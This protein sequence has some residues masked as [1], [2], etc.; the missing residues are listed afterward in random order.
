MA[1]EDA[2]KLFVAG[3]PEAMSE[4]GLRELFASSGSNVE[5]LSMPRDRMTGRPRGFAFVR[6]ASSEEADAARATLDGTLVDGRSISV[7][8]FSPEPPSRGERGPGIALRSVTGSSMTREPGGAGGG[9]GGGGGMADRMGP[10]RGPGGGADSGDRTLYVGNLPYD[11]SDNDVK[12]LFEQ[13][14]IPAP[15]RI[16]LPTDPE[17]R[18]RGFGFVTVA[19]AEEA[20][21]SLDKLKDA[22]VRGR[23]LVVNIAHPKGDRPAPRAGGGFGGPP[24]GGFDRGGPGGGGGGGGPAGGGYGGAG[25]PGG[26]GGAPGTPDERRRRTF[27]ADDKPGGASAAFG[28]AGNKKRRPLEPKNVD[29]KRGGGGSGGGWEEDDY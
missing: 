7:R 20:V 22:Q 16:H 25:G 2:C 21:S 18:K 6:L 26:P 14:A 4:E 8:P 24:G 13:L 12:E 19:S 29:K 9:G 23:R 11:A 17:G 5:D 3:L 15:Q 1:N 28:K 27:T 10:P